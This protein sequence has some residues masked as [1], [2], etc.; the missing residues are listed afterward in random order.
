MPHLPEHDPDI[1]ARERE[2]LAAIDELKARL[3]ACHDVNEAE[4]LRHAIGLHT[5]QV[6]YMRRNRQRAKGPNHEAT[7]GA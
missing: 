2:M 5:Q 6:W 1:P 3:F 7:G 4:E